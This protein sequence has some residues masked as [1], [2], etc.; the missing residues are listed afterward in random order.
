M[1]FRVSLLSTLCG[2]ACLSASALAQGAPPAAAP[3]GAPPAAASVP[4]PVTV[5]PQPGADA[6]APAPAAGGDRDKVVCKIM[7]PRT[8]TRLGGRKVCRTQ[9]QWDAMQ[10]ETKRT[11]DDLHKMQGGSKGD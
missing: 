6:A 11:M 8:G 2:I 7:P 3:A 10:E 1:R 9:R 5:M 4:A